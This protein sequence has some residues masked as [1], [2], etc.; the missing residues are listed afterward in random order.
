MMVGGCVINEA[1]VIKINMINKLC[2]LNLNSE[3]ISKI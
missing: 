3:Q 2:A 1:I